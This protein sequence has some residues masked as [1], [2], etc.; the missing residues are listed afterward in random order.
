MFKF[1]KEKATKKTIWFCGVAILVIGTIMYSKVFG[2]ITFNETLLLDGIVRY[3]V[4]KF[5]EVLALATQTDRN[6]YLIIHFIDYFFMTACFAWIIFI[7]AN[8]TKN[9]KSASLANIFI[10]IPLIGLLFDVFEDVSMDIHLLNYPDQFL[11]LA[12][13]STVSTTVKYIIS[14]TAI[15]LAI[16]LFIRKLINNKK[17]TKTITQ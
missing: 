3:N 8:L 1:I 15:L 6:S 2:L 5:Y 16:G 10:T 14:A 12:H 9:V 4:D 11:F 13:L 7:I 17:L